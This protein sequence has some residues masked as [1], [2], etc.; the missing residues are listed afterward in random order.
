[1]NSEA[2]TVEHLNQIESQLQKIKMEKV[3]WTEIIKVEDRCAAFY[4]S[5][6]DLKKVLE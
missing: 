4:I 3:D 5:K 6:M 1:M 2:V